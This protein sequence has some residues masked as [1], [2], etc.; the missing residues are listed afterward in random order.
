MPR[1]TPYV[2]ARSAEQASKLA[3]LT[4]EFG[5]KGARLAYTRPRP[6]DRDSHGNLWVR[7]EAPG[8]PGGVLYDSM[9]PARQRA[10]MER[11]LCQVCAEPADRDKDGRLFIDWRREDSPPTWPE[12]SLTAMPP[13]CA[14]H[15]QLSLRQC[16]FPRRTEHAVLRVRKPLLYGVSGAL[17]RMTEHGWRASDEDVLTPYGKPRHPGMLAARVHR[18]LRGV[19]VV[20]VPKP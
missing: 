3:E 7:M 8:D 18:E 11:M 20:D 19:T 1:A 17:H 9:H 12:R 2:A 4:V 5:P 13:L 14:A 16:P 15:V 10:C 6:G